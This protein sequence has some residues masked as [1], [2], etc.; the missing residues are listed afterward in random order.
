MIHSISSNEP[1]FRQVTFKDGLNV[2]LATRT[3]ESSRKDS[4]NGLG[5][6]TLV[7]ILHFCLGA[8]RPKGLSNATLNGWTFT[9][10][11]D[12]GGRVY[13]VSRTTTNHS[14]VLVDGDCSDWPIRTKTI[15]GKWSFSVKEWKDV[16]GS[17]MYGLSMEQNTKYGPTFRSLISYFVRRDSQGGYSDPFLNNSRQPA[18]NEQVN[19][20]Y[21]LGLNWELASQRQILRERDIALRTI[22]RKTAEA[23]V[24]EAL[25]GEAEL[26]AARIR[27]MDE[28]GV[29]KERIDNFRI[30]ETYRSL[31]GDVNHMTE[32]MHEMLNQNVD[33]K[34]LLKLYRASM[35]EETDAD[36]AQI[37]KIYEEAGTIVSGRSHQ[38]IG[39]CP[40][41]P[42][43]D[44][45]EP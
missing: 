39:G 11:L 30:H 3:Q 42:Q 44:S 5:K 7:D 4:T 40:T 1:S 15:D 25:G 32:E 38:T 16:L 8:D 20:A 17:M 36:P 23:I 13:S 2:I 37:T 9:V 21:L 31:E 43:E 29:E 12:I 24:G 45:A 6:S 33:D 19:N 34:R 41:I 27:L 10:T 35:V 26:E 22:R 14:K 28:I 18:W